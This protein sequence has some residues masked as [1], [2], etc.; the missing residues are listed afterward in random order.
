MHKS[1]GP[2]EI[3]LEFHQVGNQVRVAA[4]DADTGTEVI[5]VA[6]ATATRQQMQSIAIAKLKRKLA[7]TGS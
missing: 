1:S 7:G 6:P 3:L 4:I 2:G 5:V